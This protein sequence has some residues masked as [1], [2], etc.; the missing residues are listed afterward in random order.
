MEPEQARAVAGSILCHL[1]RP[2]RFAV[3]P[4][5]RISRRFTRTTLLVVAVSLL[6]ACSFFGK[7]KK[8]LVEILDR[9]DRGLKRAEDEI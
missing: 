6:S 7:D 1:H 8:G 9:L 3:T 4:Q 2:R 5:A